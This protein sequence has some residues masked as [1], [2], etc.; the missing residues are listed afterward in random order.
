MANDMETSGRRLLL[1]LDKSDVYVLDCVDIIQKIGG[2]NYIKGV[3][4]TSEPLTPDKIGTDVKVTYTLES[5]NTTSYLGTLYSYQLKE[6]VPMSDLYYF[7]LEAKPWFELLKESSNCRIFQNLTTQSIISSIFSE[8][9]FSGCYEFKL[10][11]SDESREYCVQFNESDYDFICRIISELGWH[12]HFYDE[13]DVQ[14]LII[15][16]NNQSFASCSPDTAAYISGSEDQ[17][18]SITSWLPYYQAS[19]GK[20]RTNDYSS[21][22][23]S[24]LDSSEQTA[25]SETIQS[26]QHFYT[27]PAKSSTTVQSTATA[28]LLVQ[29]SDCQSVKYIAKSSL[30]Y[31][32][33]AKQFTLSAHDDESFNQTYVILKSIH[34]I[35]DSMV[36]GV[37]FSNEM[38]VLP[39]SIEF[40]NF[41]L[42][43]KQIHSLQSAIVVGPSGDEVYRDSQNRIKVQ[44]HWDL[45]GESNENSS[46]WIRVSQV[47]AGQGF[48]MMFT[49]RIGDEVLV[50]FIDGDPDKPIVLGSV[51]HEK[52]TPPF[53]SS[54]QFGLMSR[55]T[56]SGSTS[57]AHI[58]RFDDAKDSEEIYLQSEKDFNV[59]V[60]NNCASQV[61]GDETQQVDKSFTQS[62]TGAVALTTEDAYSISATKTMKLD[63]TE[64][65][66]IVSAAAVGVTASD[67]ISLNASSDIENT[68]TNITLD[69]SSSIKLTCGSSEISMST[70]SISISSPSISIAATG[71]AEL[72]GASVTVEGEGTVTVKGV[73]AELNG[74]ATAKVTSS[75]IVEISGSL[76]T[77]N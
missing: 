31:L 73:T 59:L 57:N 23:V 11:G 49:P 44:F 45:E 40:K 4:L 32:T 27:Y 22:L 12:F 26:S 48:G 37:S 20:A 18:D 30:T 68:A 10:V 61:Q 6:H 42:D 50:G 77:I 1:T 41:P 60:K 47:M 33:G 2:S 17:Y 58:L 24:N 16:D 7:Y 74:S 62:V 35:V 76:T 25:T 56:P 8:L 52:N 64:D 28:K 70:S 34:T 46:A 5:G 63:S 19:M 38:E 3:L 69:G 15:G 21:S 36:D 67:N 75:G 65:F 39:A 9:G 13:S 53:S 43:R 14:K 66:S 72:T 29:S 54:T 71:T 51:H 55:S